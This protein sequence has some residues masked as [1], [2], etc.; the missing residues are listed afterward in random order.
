MDSTVL[1][2]DVDGTLTKPRQ[3]IDEKMVQTLKN[4]KCKFKIGIVGGSDLDKIKEQI[5]EENVGMFDFVFAENGLVSFRDGKLIEVKSIVEHLGEQNYQKIINACLLNLSKYEIPKKR[6]NFIEL[7]NGMINLSLVGR[8]CTQQERK[9]FLEY[10]TVNHV[11]E[12]LIEDLK[13]DI[14]PS[15][16]LVYSIGGEISI[17][18]TIKGWTKDYCL[19]YLTEFTD[20]KFFGDKTSPGGNDYE[21]S[22]DPRVQQSFTVK[23]PEDTIR[24]LNILQRI[25]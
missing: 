4:A 10:D 24:H 15:L 6:S 21:I 17:D 7:R 22:V 2:F 19:R 11:R 14:D 9:E 20:I 16:D 13:R 8:K 1:L 12:R 25:Y 5:G 18:I 3:K 23:S